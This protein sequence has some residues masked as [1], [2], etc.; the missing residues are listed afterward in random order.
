MTNSSSTP[1]EH[2]RKFQSLCSP[3]TSKSTVRAQAPKLLLLHY[4]RTN[5][6]IQALSNTPFPVRQSSTHIVLMLCSLSASLMSTMRGSLIIPRSITRRLFTSVLVSVPVVGSLSA[7]VL[8]CR[9]RSCT[10]TQHVRSMLGST[11]FLDA[12]KPLH[13]TCM[14]T[15]D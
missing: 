3:T 5:S 2:F 8:L 13:R 9:L 14:F 15:G 12:N 6:H 11:F 10:E 4:H 7:E 1:S